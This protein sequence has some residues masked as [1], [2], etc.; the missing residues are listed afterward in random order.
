VTPDRGG[1]SLLEALVAMVILAGAAAAILPLLQARA[2]FEFRAAERLDQATALVAAADRSV[3]GD[4]RFR[5]TLDDEVLRLRADTFALE[6]RNL[7]VARV[8]VPIAD[9]L[10]PHVLVDVVRADDRL[11][12][13]VPGARYAEPAENE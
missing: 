2:D 12:L 8:E 5:R 13:V 7:P 6:I 3:I 1:F 10:A 11:T 9:G 4:A